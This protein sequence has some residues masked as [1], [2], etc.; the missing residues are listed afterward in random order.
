MLDERGANV[1]AGGSR[2]LRVESKLPHFICLSSGEDSSAVTLYTFKEGITRIGNPDSNDEE[3]P[4]QDVDLHGDGAEPEHAIVEFDISLNEE[5]QQLQEVR[6]PTY[7]S[8]SASETETIRDILANCAMRFQISPHRATAQ[9][10]VLHPIAELCYINGEEM[11]DSVKLRHG[12]LIQLGEENLFRFNHPTEAQRLRKLKKS[13]KKAAHMAK[14]GVGGL[15]NALALTIRLTRWNVPLPSAALQFQWLL[16][17]QMLGGRNKQ[18]EK[19]KEKENQRK[20]DAMRRQ[21]DQEKQAEI[22]RLEELRREAQKEAQAEIDRKAA[23]TAQLLAQM[24]AMKR[25]YE[26]Q[27][28]EQL[29]E[30]QSKQEAEKQLLA[31]EQADH[32]QRTQ[33]EMK[34]LQD[35][36]EAEMRRQAKEMEHAKAETVAIQ[37]KVCHVPLGSVFEQHGVA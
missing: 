24:E 30:Q 11:E 26:T 10:I 29:R 32:K 37:A 35:E 8:L 23:E 19:E 9:V 36:R 4:Q 28:A 21:L 33:E 15:R 12:D 31:Q 5:L 16:P 25:Q 27:M 17:L 20:L 22:N 13:G 6:S 2:G 18:A 1:T 34:R 3:T 14:V 7:V